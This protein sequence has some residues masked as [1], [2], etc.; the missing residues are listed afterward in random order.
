M[1]RDLPWGCDGHHRGRLQGDGASSGVTS[2]VVFCDLESKRNPPQ[3]IR[4]GDFLSLFIG[5]DGLVPCQ[6]NLLDNTALAA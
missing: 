5:A 1:G 3:A 2:L 6:D 4:P